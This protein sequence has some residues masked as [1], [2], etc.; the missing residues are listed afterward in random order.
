MIA[1]PTQDSG[2]RSLRHDRTAISLRPR[3]AFTAVELI[4]VIAIIG[5]LIALLLPAVLK[6]REAANR[7]VC[8]NHLKQIGTAFHTHHDAYKFFPTGGW[9]WW[10]PPNYMPSGQPYV[11][12]DQYAG[13]GFQ[14]LPF[15][16]GDNAYQAGALAAITTPNSVFFCPTRRAPM[17]LPHPDEYTPSLN[18]GTIYAALCDYAASNLEGTGVVRQYYPNRFADIVDGTSNTL[19]VGE[20]R[21]DL[22]R[23]GI[24]A[25]DDNEGYTC[26]WDHDVIRRTDIPPGQDPPT[27]DTWTGDDRFGSSHQGQCHFVFADGSVRAISYA[28][29]PLIFSYMGNMS[30][31]QVIPEG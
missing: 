13:W 2:G 25:P 26:G 24:G 23:I 1:A 15:L 18:D 28:I 7:A 31:G 5:V 10:T 4:V 16:E 3:Q 8:R 29:D 27:S 21:L 12:T 14:I 19:L 17:V 6:A 9:E 30:D 11:G 20:K 22:Q